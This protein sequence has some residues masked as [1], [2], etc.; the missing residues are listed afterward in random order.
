MRR[1][2]WLYVFY[3]NGTDEENEKTSSVSNFICLTDL[4]FHAFLY[5]YMPGSSY[6][7]SHACRTF[8]SFPVVRPATFSHMNE[9]MNGSGGGE[10]VRNGLM[11]CQ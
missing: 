3:M 8:L 6:A 2:V 7:F 4:P 5:T 11:V 9:E 10:E 1:H